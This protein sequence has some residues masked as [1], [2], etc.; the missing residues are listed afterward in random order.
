M[1]VRGLFFVLTILV[2]SIAGVA[3]ATNGDKYCIHNNSTTFLARHSGSNLEF[4]LSSW[5]GRGHYFAIGGVA[6]PVVGGWV[7]HDHMESL[8][9][10]TRCEAHILAQP[11]GGYTFWL[12]PAGP[13]GE[14]QG[15]SFE[16]N[17]KIV[18][19]PRS[20]RGGIPANK[21]MEQAGSPEAGGEWC[22]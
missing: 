4:S 16:P 5:S 3:A 2:F 19:P 12:T 17:A 21:T 8:N 15:F 20:R 13:C 18:F 11:A 10:E 6:N 14:G 9:L 7:F 1:L 22:R